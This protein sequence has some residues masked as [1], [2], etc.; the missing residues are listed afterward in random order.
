MGIFTKRADPLTERARD[1]QS[2]LAAV[3]AEIEKLQGGAPAAHAGPRLRSTAMPDGQR[4]INRHEEPA[5]PPAAQ[6]PT[7]APV[8]IESLPEVTP[9][10]MPAPPPVRTSAS[11]YNELGVRKFDLAGW[12]QSMKDR[13]TGAP[14]SASKIL[15]LL[16]A[17]TLH[18][19]R[20]LR[21]E[22]RVARNRFIA[23]FI[24]LLLALLG[25]FTMVLK[26]F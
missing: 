14:S 16:N 9:R 15:P 8:R 17:G 24:V 26:N 4:V 2:E 11:H 21:Y 13:V 5:P 6:V 7:P 18:G 12:W 20:P 22:Q 3:Q 23:L 25:L 10:L 1:L 19:P